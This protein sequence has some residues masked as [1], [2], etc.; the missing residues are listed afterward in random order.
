MRSVVR[1]TYKGNIP[2]PSKFI[3][4][5]C[6]GA[7]RPSCSFGLGTWA[8]RGPQDWPCP[9]WEPASCRAW[10]QRAELRASNGL[11]QQPWRFWRAMS[12]G[13]VPTARPHQEETAMGPKTGT[14]PALLKWGVMAPGWAEMEPWTMS[15]VGGDPGCL[16]KD[17]KVLSTL[18]ALARLYP[19]KNEISFY[20][21]YWKRGASTF[22]SRFGERGF[23]STNLKAAFADVCLMFSNPCA[24]DS[25]IITKISHLPYL[26]LG[27]HSRERFS[28][29]MVEKN[30][31]F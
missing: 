1:I 30:F 22:C 20:L 15:G 4:V 26:W 13:W 12:Q 16:G 29:L 7:V 6:Q 21:F 23:F 17:R 31:S 28:F 14:A 9:P 8:P 19:E 11:H 24:T 25:W 18:R 2:L 27:V 5:P 3:L 10:A